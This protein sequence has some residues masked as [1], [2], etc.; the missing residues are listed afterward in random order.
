M[1]LLQKASF[2]T[3]TRSFGTSITLPQVTVWAMVQTVTTKG[4]MK[5]Q[6][7][8]D[9]LAWQGGFSCFGSRWTHNGP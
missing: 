9:H 7:Q 8:D 1:I 3:Q 5:A 4:R 6:R 2:R